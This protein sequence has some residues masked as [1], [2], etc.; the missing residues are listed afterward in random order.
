MGRIFSVEGVFTFHFS[1]FWAP[2][3]TV[4]I[5]CPLP[6]FCGPDPYIPPSWA[7][8]QHFLRYRPHPF[9]TLL[10]SFPWGECYSSSLRFDSSSFPTSVPRVYS[11]VL[12]VFPFG[13]FIVT[14]P[15]PF[16]SWGFLQSVLC[17]R[18]V[19]FVFQA[20]FSFWNR[21]HISY[22][23]CVMCAFKP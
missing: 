4:V 14:P 1:L 17:L 19:Q 21:V 6:F 3:R 13:V 9:D 12:H 5:F 22:L 11:P 8:L 18:T 15:F 7:I 16:L 2:S 20:Y 23:F 10:S